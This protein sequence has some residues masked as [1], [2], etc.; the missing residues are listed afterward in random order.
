[1]HLHFVNLVSRVRGRNLLPSLMSLE[2]SCSGLASSGRASG[3]YYWRR[4]GLLKGY[5]GHGDQISIA[6]RE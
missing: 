1:M 3:G 6:I 2:P 4:R 5:S